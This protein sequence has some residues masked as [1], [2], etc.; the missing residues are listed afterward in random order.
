M[1]QMSIG[2]YYLEMLAPLVMSLGGIRNRDACRSS[3]ALIVFATQIPTGVVF[4]SFCSFLPAVWAPC[5]FLYR[6]GISLDLLAF[7]VL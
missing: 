6:V 4:V 1:M 2:G 5:A 7:S 3:N